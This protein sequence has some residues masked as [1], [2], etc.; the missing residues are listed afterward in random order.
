MLS[1]LIGTALV[2]LIVCVII[3]GRLLRDLNQEVRSVRTDLNDIIYNAHSIQADLSALKSKIDNLKGMILEDIRSTQAQSRILDKQ[4]SLIVSTSDFLIETREDVGLLIEMAEQMESQYDDGPSL[5]EGEDAL[6]NPDGIQAID[7]REGADQNHKAIPF[8]L[9][10][11][12]NGEVY[13]V[14]IKDGISPEDTLRHYVSTDQI[15]EVCV[16]V[17]SHKKVSTH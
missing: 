7:L 6:L 4:T 8:M 16:K 9:I 5:D 13:N 15:D 3:T 1:L 12:N 17:G 11:S 14:E 2:V 10:H